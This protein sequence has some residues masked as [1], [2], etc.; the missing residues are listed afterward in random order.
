MKE[1]GLTLLLVAAT[2]IAVAAEPEN[3]HYNCP[4]YDIQVNVDGNLDEKVWGQLDVAG[5]FFVLKQTAAAEKKTAF[6]I[7]RN[8]QAFYLGIIVPELTPKKINATRP[9]NGALWEEDSIEVFLSD[10]LDRKGRYRQYIFSLSGARYNGF[11]KEKRQLGNWLG[12]LTRQD[13]GF[14]IELEIPYSDIGWTPANGKTWQLNVC[15]ND[16]V[17]ES[18]KNTT[19]G[20]VRPQNNLHTKDS[21]GYLHLTPDNKVH[22]TDNRTEIIKQ[23]YGE[24]F[25]GI[26]LQVRNNMDYQLGLV[27]LSGPEKA[28]RQKTGEAKLKEITEAFRKATSPQEQLAEIKRLEMFDRQE[29][30]LCHQ[31]LLSGIIR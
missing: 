12:K 25:A 17:S 14:V 20:F 26:L 19:W 28:Q 3:R 9:D 1:F 31:Q 10:N 29:K 21:F 16:T 6:K 18:E 15:R 30:Q 11:M 23:Y 24:I 22:F 2:V 13:S 8:R 27:P 4:F 7:F 5:D